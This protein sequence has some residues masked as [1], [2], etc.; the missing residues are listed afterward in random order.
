[1]ELVPSIG[2]CDEMTRDPSRDAE[3]GTP[4]WC[5]RSAGTAGVVSSSCL[6]CPERGA[7]PFV[8]IKGDP[9]SPQNEAPSTV[10][11]PHSPQ[12]DA[13]LT[14]SVPQQYR[15]STSADCYLHQSRQASASVVRTVAVGPMRSRD[16]HTS[17]L[18]THD[19]SGDD[20]QN[21]T[22]RNHP[23]PVADSG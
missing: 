10:L 2:A 15:R 17:S 19:Q 13:P 11:A 23:H 4:T 22:H 6:A 8:L 5:R 3:L 12:N 7:S 21:C 18:I 9:Q 16:A 1:V 14:A 20:R